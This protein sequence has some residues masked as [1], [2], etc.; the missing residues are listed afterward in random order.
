MLARSQ[1]KQPYRSRH[2][3]VT[4]IELVIGIT[5][6]AIALTL[7]TSILSPLFIK[8]S[9]PWHQVRATELGQSLMNEILARSFDENSD[10]AGGLLRCGETGAP[11]CTAAAQFGPDGAES[12]EAYNDVD[13]FQGFV[14]SAAELTNLLGT[15]LAEQYRNYQVAI[16]ISYPSANQVTGMVLAANQAK[17]IEIT[18]TTPTGAIVQFA[19]YRGNW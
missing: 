17:K 10:R 14:G 18:V 5:V 4:L 3:G 7:I 2:A 9:D 12:R 8:S 13:D 16:A 11:A 6:L 1:S 19:A 15:S